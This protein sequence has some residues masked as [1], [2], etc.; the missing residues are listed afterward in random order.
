MR[1]RTAIIRHLW[2]EGI[3]DPF[4]LLNVLE[5]RRLLQGCS[6]VLDVGC[7]YLSPLRFL[8]LEHSVGIDGYAPDLEKAK[9]RQTHKEFVLGDI[10]E[11]PQ[12]FKSKQ[13]DACVALDVIEHLPKED[14]YKL[15]ESMQ[16][17][18]KRRIIFLTPNG[19]LP[20]RSQER[21][22]LQQHL[23]GW[24]ADEMAKLGFEVVGMLG[25]KSYR[26]EFH[27]LKKTPRLFWA[28]MSLIQQLLVTRG[29]P[30]GAAAILCSKE[31][32]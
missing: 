21:D 26:G 29:N 20:Q 22:D 18:A 31:L 15:I 3:Y 9:N 25:P 12:K 8:G 2:K 19:F 13:F 23:S 6:H 1:S 14:G 11:L 30:A 4:V 28:V 27:R 16:A 7:G 10:R 17:V 24:S 5:L 32:R